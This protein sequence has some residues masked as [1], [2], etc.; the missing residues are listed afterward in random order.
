MNVKVW[1]MTKRLVVVLC[2]L[3][4]VVQVVPSCM[5]RLGTAVGHVTGVPR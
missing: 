3:F 2:L 5:A 1:Q 4:L